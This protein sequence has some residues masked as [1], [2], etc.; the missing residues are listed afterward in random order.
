MSHSKCSP[1]RPRTQP[2]T[3]IVWRGCGEE[4]QT[5][6]ALNHPNIATIHG[7]VEADGIRALVLELVEGQTLAERLAAGPMAI[8]DAIAFARQIA[9]AL[10]AAHE[11]GIV[12]RDL[13]PSNVKLRPDGTVKLLDFGLAKIVRPV[14]QRR[15]CGEPAE[16]TACR[17]MHRA[18]CRYR[19]VHEPGAG[20]RPRGRSP[21]RH[22]GV[23]RG[24][25]RDA[26]GTS[27]RSRA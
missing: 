26:L 7:L 27:A 24:A 12:H 10:E 2:E 11:Q 4:A 6:A 9:V 14:S 15:R 17:S 3:T 13:K 21:E 25:V 20:A 19:G 23:R 16:S 1:S 8:D 22:L 18:R 5:L